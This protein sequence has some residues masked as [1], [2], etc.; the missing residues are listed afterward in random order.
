MST[1]WYSIATLP[2]VRYE[3]TELDKARRSCA[4]KNSVKKGDV[5]PHVQHDEMKFQ[6]S[7]ENSRGQQIALARATPLWD[8]NDSYEKKNVIRTEISHSNISYRISLNSYGL[9][10]GSLVCIK[11]ESEN[12]YQVFDKFLN[13]YQVFVIFTGCHA[14][15]KTYIYMI[16]H[17]KEHDQLSIYLN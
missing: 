5:Y 12:A 4:D 16:H 2:G 8:G 15:L 10:F 11:E 17:P 7:V 6:L 14:A 3:Y 9:E 13:A 1:D